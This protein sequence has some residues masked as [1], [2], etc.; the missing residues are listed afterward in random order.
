[1]MMRTR[2]WTAVLC[3]VALIFASGAS[4]EGAFTR[5]KPITIDPLQV[6]GSSDLSSFP[7]LVS[8]VDT[9]L[10][11]APSGD[12]TSALGHDILFRA[13]DDATC[14][15]VGTAPCILDHEIETYDPSSGTLVAWVRVPV[16]STLNPTVLYVYYGDAAVTS[17][18][19][20]PQGVWDASFRE[21]FHLDETGDH[22]DSTANGYSMV[23]L[24]TVTQG[25][26][27]KVGPAYE[28]H[29]P[30]HSRAI[31]SDGAMGASASHTFEAWI[32]LETLQSGQFTGYV[33]KGRDSGV[34]W[35]GLFKSGSDRIS[36]GWQC[37]NPPTQPGNLNGPVLSTGQWYYAAATFD[38]VGKVRTLYVDGAPVATDVNADHAGF[39]EYL[40]IGDDSNGQYH[41]GFLDEI[42]VSDVARSPDWIQT[43]H[44]N[45]DI[46]GSF[47]AVGGEDPA[48]PAVNVATTLEAP[49]LGIGSGTCHFRSIGTRPVYGT[50]EAEGAPT[51]VS[52]TTGSTIVTGAGTGRIT[53]N[54]GRGDRINIG[55]TDYTILSVDTETQLK[56]TT[57]F[58]GASGGG[59]TYAISRKFG[60]L[61]SW[62]ACIDGPGGAGCEGVSSANL[63]TD[64]RAEVGIAYNDGT[65]TAAGTVLNINNSITDATHDI[66]LTVDPGNRHTGVAG[67]GVLVD[68]GG[69]NTLWAVAVQDDHVTVEWLR[70]TGGSGTGAHGFNVV[71]DTNQNRIVI[72]NNLVHDVTGMGIRIN[73]V[74]AVVDVY[75]NIVY[76]TGNQVARINQVLLPGSRVRFLN[77]TFYNPTGSGIGSAAA[78]NPHVLFRNNIIYDSSAGFNP[79]WINVGSSN[80]LSDDV[81]PP[82]HPSTLFVPDT[83]HSPSGGGVYGASIPSASFLD[84]TGGSENL[85]IQGGSTAENQAASLSAVFT[86]NIDGVVR[87]APWDIGA[88]EFAASAHF[89]SIGTVANYTTGSVTATNGSAVVSGATTSW[90]SANRGRGDRITIDSV[91]Y[92]ILSVTSETSLLLTSPFGGASGA[93]KSYTIARKFATLAAWEDCVDGA[94]CEGVASTSLVTDNR[95]EVGIAYDDSV[96]TVGILID[97]STTDATH[98]IT[99]TADD[100]NRHYGIGGTGV[101]LDNGVS[102][103]KAVQIQD[104]HV[105]FEWFEVKNG[106][107][108][109]DG[110]D[111]ANLGAPN[112]IVLRSLIVHN[113]GSSGIQLQ[114]PDLKASVYNNIVYRSV[115]R[116][117]RSSVALNAGASINIFNNTLFANASQGIQATAGGQPN[118]TLRNNVA[119]S[120]SSGDYDVTVLSSTSSHNIAGDATG[121]SHSPG[122]GGTDNVPLANRRFVSTTI[123]VENFHI[124][125][126]SAAEGAA[127][128]LSGSFTNDVDNETRDASWDAGADDITTVV[129]YRSIGTRPN[130]GNAGPE[131]AGTT[132]TATN[133]SAV[134]TGSPGSGWLGANRGRGDRITIDGPTTPSSPSIL[135]P[136]SVSRAPSSARRRPARVHHR[137]KVRNPRGLGGLH[138]RARR[139]R[140]RRGL[141]LEPRCRQPA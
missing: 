51:T 95:S 24:G 56:L 137:E 126:G 115:T 5:R 48:P 86:I 12:V 74:D 124:L 49:C 109:A 29:G 90:Q 4:V 89:R 25:V 45:Q 30:T 8:L 130:Y 82:S 47:Y 39:V 141:E 128:D 138:R 80:N 88:D 22:T 18:L 131:G 116:G 42:R 57:P 69:A 94:G 112:Y 107:G 17:P 103:T 93:G 98:T 127:V 136:S 72:R 99:L 119:H 139:C 37:C 3:A 50:V 10:M 7:V 36:L 54:R 13:E 129:H 27:G 6:T 58:T 87:D 62:E 118:L 77:N 122:T 71:A 35:S 140:M 60:T 33:T 111:V 133:G 16:L 121:V 81:A 110:V 61:A 26:T 70:I 68:N 83:G 135:I 38:G 104:D 2:S 73:S 40:R 114:E 1:M 113:T 108:G 63:V 84:T 52:A 96:F 19:Q 75:N 31:A 67:T 59:K 102:T 85:H 97:G 55:G 14:G 132:V 53:A 32:Y 120:N 79:A 91:D 11:L 100:G 21:V 23:T 78:S 92:T 106:I 101:E 134:V 123:G 20:N 44:N 43:S 28:F 34:E 65:Y 76:E 9:D 64:N 46:P 15:G 41:D 66:T 125:N 117:I 105:T